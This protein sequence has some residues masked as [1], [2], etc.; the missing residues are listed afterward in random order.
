MQAEKV[1]SLE[2]LT[3]EQIEKLEKI[4]E[5]NYGSHFDLQQFFVL[6]TSEDKMWIATKEVANMAFE[7]I[8][9]NSIGLYLGK[10]KRNDK[11]NL[12][13]EGCQLVGK[14]AKKN[15]ALL[16]EEAAER[17]LHGEDVM[18]K[19]AVNCEEHNFVM[20]KHEGDFLGSSP[21]EGKKI[22]NMLPKSRR[23]AIL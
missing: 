13:V 20:V 16:D 18:P 17:F 2:I 23:L 1:R 9:V 19:E 22:K 14:D 12:S 11:I 21:F 8:P 10:I 5:K 15:V 7:K 4:V 3:K 6:K